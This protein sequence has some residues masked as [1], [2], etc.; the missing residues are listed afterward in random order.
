MF[1]PIIHYGSNISNF[2]NQLNKIKEG[3]YVGFVLASDSVIEMTSFGIDYIMG[4]LDK[5]ISSYI[6]KNANI[7]RPNTNTN[8]TC[9]ELIDP[10]HFDIQIISKKISQSFRNFFKSYLNFILKKS[11][12]AVTIN[13]K[14]GDLTETDQDPSINDTQLNN[15]LSNEQL[16]KS[17]ILILDKLHNLYTQQ[18]YPVFTSDGAYYVTWVKKEFVDF[19]EEEMFMGSIS[20]P[21][22]VIINP[23]KYY[24]HRLK[25]HLFDDIK[26]IKD[27]LIDAHCDNKIDENEGTYDSKNNKTE[28]FTGLID[29][30]C[31]NISE[32]CDLFPD[33]IVFNHNNK[34]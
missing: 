31:Q 20:K 24:A 30:I 10:M 32:L 1:E 19:V 26:S 3:S 16:M 15:L 9:S 28:F 14:L 2:E 18:S 25:Y 7:G 4:S 5:N 6:V 29:N 27:N 17:T 33:E 34:I 23:N 13:K 12:F 22:A 8:T 21:H 11:C